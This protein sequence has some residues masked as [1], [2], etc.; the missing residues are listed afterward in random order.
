MPRRVPCLPLNRPD[1]R[2]L[3]RTH[4]GTPAAEPRAASARTGPGQ[5]RG[6]AQGPPPPA[7]ARRA[8]SSASCS[9]SASSRKKISNRCSRASSACRSSRGRSSRTSRCRSA[10]CSFKYLR[11]A[12]VLP[13]AQSNGALVVAMSDPGDY[14][15]IQ[16]LQM[17]TGLEIEPRLARERDI[18]EALDQAYAGGNG[19]EGGG[20]GEGDAEV[21]VRRRGRGGRQPP[22]RPRER[23]ARHPAREPAHQ[24]RRREPRVGH[25]RRAVRGAA[26]GP[27]PHRRR[28]ARRR[29]AAAP[30]ARPRSSRA[31]RS[32]RS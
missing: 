29:D 17:A 22:P 15:A 26:E 20:N 13:L 12:K 30:P 27:L 4:G 5:R 1:G 28:A 19:A 11:R 24:P 32:W 23:S 3:C 9:I 7:G 31:S 2:L 16:G 10:R 25:P 21:A 18:V 8:C 14:Y 6:S